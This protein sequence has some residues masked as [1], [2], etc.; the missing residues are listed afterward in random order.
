MGKT[1]NN[2]LGKLDESISEMRR[3]AHN[4]MP[5]ALMKLGLQ[6]A[7]QDYCE[8]LSEGQPFVINSQFHGLEKRMDAATEVVVYRIVQEL[9]NNAVK[10]SGASTILAQVMRQENNLTITVEDD[11]KGFDKE[12]VVQGAGLKNIRSR[13]D[14][15]KGQLDIQTKDGKG[16]SVHIDCIIEHNG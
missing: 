14:Y 4:L 11:G 10:H 7:L 3:V 1:F 16:T 2:A 6:Q 5:E 8:G 15:L 13:V 9:L 12:A